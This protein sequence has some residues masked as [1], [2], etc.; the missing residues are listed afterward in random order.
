MDYFD[1][2]KTSGVG[3]WSDNETESKGNPWDNIPA[4]EEYQPDAT[5]FKEEPNH[6]EI[7]ETQPSPTDCTLQQR[8]QCLLDAFKLFRNKCSIDN[9]N[10]TD[11][12]FLIW[13]ARYFLRLKSTEM[14]EIFT[15]HIS[16]LYRI[17]NKVNRVI[18]KK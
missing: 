1:F 6:D 3:T 5:L 12:D 17:S 8:F 13:M 2:I 15:L 4:G 7:T 14:D 18:F 9:S 10:N 11:R 16:N